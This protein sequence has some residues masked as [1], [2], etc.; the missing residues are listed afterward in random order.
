LSYALHRGAE[1]DLAEAFR[2]LRREAGVGIARR[3]LEEFE[4]VMNLLEQF[5]DIGKLTS[6]NRRSLPLTGFPYA[7]I[8]RHVDSGIR[9]LVVRHQHRDPVHGDQRS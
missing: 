7:V 2:F 1:Q 3:F 6:E 5:P 9:V 4:R 8:Y